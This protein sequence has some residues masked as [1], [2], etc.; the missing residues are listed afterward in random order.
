MLLATTTGVINAVDLAL[1]EAAGQ[2]LAAAGAGRQLGGWQGGGHVQ[3]TGTGAL[4]LIEW[5]I[6]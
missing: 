3:D 2:E 1:H 4:I 6:A 5:F